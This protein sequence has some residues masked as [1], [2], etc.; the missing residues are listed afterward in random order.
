VA[1]GETDVSLVVIFPV[2]S[3]SSL[4][5]LVG[6]ALVVAGT[7][8]GFLLMA[9]MP[10]GLVHNHRDSSLDGAGQADNRKGS[11]IGGVVLIGPIP[12]AFGSS[13]RIAYAMLAVAV[14][15][16]LIMLALALLVFL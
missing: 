6:V 12:I 7:L 10:F 5:F 16:V 15:I 3:G 1:S 14:G 4:S 2:L 13:A 9:A 8:S 11:K